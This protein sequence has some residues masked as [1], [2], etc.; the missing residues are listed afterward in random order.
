MNNV[1]ENFKPEALFSAENPFFE[2]AQKTH[3]LFAEA[4]DKTARMQL[5]F[6]EELLE[7]NKKRF[8]SL[9]TGASVQDTIAN[10]QELMTE[11]GGHASALADEFQQ[12]ATDLQAG[13]TDATNEWINIATEAVNNA[14]ETAKPAK[15]A[16]VS[17]KAA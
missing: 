13:V 11:A 14:S 15:I 8:A 17:K 9:Y 3:T 2:S 12:V 10:H 4:F 16:K 5:A 6:G 7:I 1:F